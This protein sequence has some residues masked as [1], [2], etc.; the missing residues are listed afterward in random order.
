MARAAGSV[1]ARLIV[2]NIPYFERGG[3]NAMPA[4]LKDALVRVD[5]P[6]LSV[7]DLAPVVER[8]Y[9][10]PAAPLLRFERDRH[11]NPAA[12]A[13]I[14]DAID[15]FVRDRGLLPGLPTAR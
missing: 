6:N 7:V 13:L 11:P 10:D 2:L 12:H 5:A 3:T 1:G 15:G 4:P 8:H 9:A 14:A